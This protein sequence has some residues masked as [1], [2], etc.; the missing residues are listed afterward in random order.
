[1]NS[2]KRNITIK[3]VVSYMILLL[4]VILVGSYLYKQIDAFTSLQQHETNDNSKVVRIGRI[5]AIMYENESFGR[6]AIQ[7]EEAE[8]LTKYIIKND[9]LAL[10][11]DSLKILTN[12]PY[13]VVLVDSIKLLLE[14]KLQNIFE[15]KSIREASESD[16]ILDEG[17]KNF[18]N[19]ESSMGKLTL[20]DFSSNPENLA[21]KQKETLE[22]IITILNKYRPRDTSVMVDE[23]TLDS[24]IVQSKT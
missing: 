17:I 24:I 13:Q 20:E 4:L 5:L 6:A 18:I 1:M 8:I 9:S 2:P 10:E 14:E 11:I 22:E 3:V 23:Q 15:L 21:K 7:S 12:S 19:I 16:S